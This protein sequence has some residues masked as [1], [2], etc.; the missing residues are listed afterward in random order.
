MVGQDLVGQP[1][2]FREPGF[3]CQF[4]TVYDSSPRGSDT[5]FWQWGPVVSFWRQAYCLGN[6]LGCLCCIINKNPETDIGVQPIDQKNNADRH[7]LIP[8][9]QSNNGDPTPGNLRM[10]LRLELSSSFC[11]LSSFEIK[12]MHHYHLVS[13][14]H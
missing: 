4:K 14:A 13:I 12:I 11:I 7:W 2:V 5:L 1:F 6:R 3:N 8:L 9:P 10:R